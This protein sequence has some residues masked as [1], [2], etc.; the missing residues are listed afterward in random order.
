V[1]TALRLAYDAT[2]LLGPRTG[3]GIM[4]ARVLERL[5]V[6]DDVTVTA[7]AATWRGRGELGGLVPSTVRAVTRPMPARPLQRAWRATNLPPIEWF[8]GHVDVVHGPNY[9][10]PPAR[11]AARIA[12][13]HDLTALHH[14][15][16]CTP[17]VRTYPL[18]I[19]R[20]LRTGAYLHTVSAFVRDEVIDA[21]GADPER[22]VV[23]HN[24]VEPIPDAD[25]T[26]GRRAARADR[27][28]LAL[29]TIEP[30]KNYPRLLQAFDAVAAEDPDIRLVIAGPDGWGMDGFETA[31]DA[32]KHHD[33]VTRLGMTDEAGR[34]ALLR[35]ATAL[36]YPSVYEGFGLPPLEAMS[37]GVP[38]MVS[39][40]GA[41]VEVVGDAAEIAPARDVDAIA[42][43]LARVIH[44][45]TRRAELIER[46]LVRAARFTWDATADGLVRLYRRVE[47]ERTT[48]R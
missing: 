22:V 39:D 40:A 4:T 48:R 37:V 26:A 36:A 41:V 12:T 46:G 45:D 20:A 17:H 10:V 35:G 3:V 16:L 2:P 21:F 32:C 8:T 23:V 27:Y 30:R 34:A 38:A 29:G 7:F 33:R 25:P 42:A 1:A 5:A 43:A 19:R 9:V 18:S 14:P 6:R 31:L 47:A 13:V 11:R 24:G 15:E 44:D 28:V